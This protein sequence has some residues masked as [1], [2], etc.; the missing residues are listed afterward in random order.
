MIIG[1]RDQDPKHLSL[2]FLES[3][4]T[5]KNSGW[6]AVLIWGYLKSFF[7]Q[8][9]R[10]PRDEFSD[11]RLD[12]GRIFNRLQCLPVAGVPKG[13]YKGSIWIEGKKGFQICV[14]PNHYC[15]KTT[16][17]AKGSS[18]SRKMKSLK[19]ISQQAK[20]FA[21]IRGSDKEVPLGSKG[22]LKAK[23][24]KDIHMD[25]D[26]SDSDD[27]N[28]H[29]HEDTLKKVLAVRLI[30]QVSVSVGFSRFQETC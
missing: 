18:R 23:T 28:H 10:M 16:L 22:M 11:L 12:L 1:P 13:H 6:D 2:F 5:L 8:K 21:D 30:V 4:D 27:D 24:F 25:F 15:L 14:N 19:S 26:H 7:A 3:D 29:S 9:R 17:V 20:D